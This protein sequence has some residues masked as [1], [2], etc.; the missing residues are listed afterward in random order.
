MDGTGPGASKRRRRRVTGRIVSTGGT[1]LLLEMAGVL[2][3]AIGWSRVDSLLYRSSR[4]AKGFQQ[5]I[6][7]LLTR[8]SVARGM[9]SEKRSCNIRTVSSRYE[10]IIIRID[11]VN[12]QKGWKSDAQ[13]RCPTVA[14]PRRSTTT[15]LFL[16]TV[17]VITVNC[18]PLI[19]NEE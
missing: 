7:I 3:M 5:G 11:G 6:C 17:T 18:S 9:D 10:S 2:V 16:I 14:P 15:S 1:G 12:K 8:F 19:N 4:V 13:D